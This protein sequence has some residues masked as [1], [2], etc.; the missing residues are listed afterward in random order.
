MTFLCPRI[1]GLISV[2]YDE[3]GESVAQVYVALP[4]I[5]ATGAR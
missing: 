1:D 3:R 4:Q 5:R 2:Q